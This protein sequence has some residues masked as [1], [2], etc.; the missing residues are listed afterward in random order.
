MSG[1]SA[2]RRGGGRGGAT[3][4]LVLLTG[5]LLMFAGGILLVLT[6]VRTGHVASVSAREAARAGATY[7]GER[8]QVEGIARARAIAVAGEHG[9]TL[10]PDQ[11]T[12]NGASGARG[13]IVHVEVRLTVAAA[14]FPLW[15]GADLITVTA[16][17]W[18]RLERYG[19]R[20]Q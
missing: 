11:V 20:G 12:V 7:E 16:G 18:Q 5:V 3:L 19:S 1:R 14:R 10:T 17:D 13:E 4:E 8:S 6:L 15:G 2:A 9:Y